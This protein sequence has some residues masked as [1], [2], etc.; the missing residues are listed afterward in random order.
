MTQQF[1]IIPVEDLA[2]IKFELAAIRQCLAG[3]TVTPKPNWVS[4][5]DA[6]TALGVS[7][8]TIRRRIN[9]GEIPAQGS[10]K[11]R[12]VKIT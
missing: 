5:K 9:T 4:I 7:P 3:A 12:R 6:A 8:Q 11:T 1:A 2:A 10:G